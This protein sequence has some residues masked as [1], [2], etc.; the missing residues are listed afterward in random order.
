MPDCHIL[1]IED[2]ALFA[3]AREREAA[4]S[5]FYS[6]LGEKI[7]RLCANSIDPTKR[8]DLACESLGFSMTAIAW[9]ALAT[10]D[11]DEVFYWGAALK[12]LRSISDGELK[13]AAK[14]VQD[15]IERRAGEGKNA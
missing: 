1:Q 3:Y 10:A 2:E 7:Y 6:E 12:H 4:P 5:A 11:R 15:E 9:R 8:S 13:L 14:R